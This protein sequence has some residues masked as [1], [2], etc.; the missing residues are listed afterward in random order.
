M[1]NDF[2][3]TVKPAFDFLSQGPGY[4]LAHEEVS[5]SF[6]NGSLIYES[7]GLRIHVTRDRGQVSFDVRARSGFRDYDEEILRLLLA[8]SRH[9]ARP[10]STPD[11]DVATSATFLRDRLTEIEHLFEPSLVDETTRKGEVLKNER[12]EVLFGK[13]SRA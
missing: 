5:S 13:A 3:T 8:G 2:L 6:D 11:F 10:S 7:S 12:A 4:R 1:A 9:Y